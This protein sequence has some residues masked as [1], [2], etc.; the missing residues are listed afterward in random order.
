MA[1]SIIGGLIARGNAA[2]N[3]TVCDPEAATLNR[4]QV[5]FGVNI[6]RDNGA[7]VANADLV[8]LAVKPQVMGAVCRDLAPHISP[9]V[10]VISIAAGIDCTRL[11]EWLGARTAIV[12]CMPNTPALVGAG[13]SGLYAAPGVTAAQQKEAEAVL[14]AVGTVAWVDREDL[15][16]AVTAVSGSGPAYFFLAMEA[17]IE[18]GVSQ[19]LS[20]ETART[21][22]L[23]TALGAAKLAQQSP[24]AVAEL[25]RRVTSPGGTTEQAIASFENNGLRRIYA[26]A[27]QACADR[28][29]TMADEFN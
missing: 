16:D 22:T 28:A 3:I 1:R 2:R 17:M 9:G 24:D 5:D 20:P 19:G 11:S 21:L 13:A 7:S 4:L 12:R 25:R 18:A 14:A 15:M 26:E 6:S 8:V 27:M 10:L 29:R 23:Q